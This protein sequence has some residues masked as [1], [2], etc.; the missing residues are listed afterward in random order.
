MYEKH[1]LEHFRK[2]YHKGSLPNS[3]G[4][5][6][7]R[8]VSEVCGDEVE[9]QASIRDGIIERICWQGE[10]CCFSLAAASMLVKYANGKSINEMKQFDDEGMFKLFQAECPPA[11]RGCVLTAFHALRNLIENFE[12]TGIAFHYSSSMLCLQHEGH[13]KKGTLKNS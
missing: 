12:T 9:I 2:P 13:T 5:F 4:V 11:R 1:V 7:G 10:G 8:S 6:S 3:P